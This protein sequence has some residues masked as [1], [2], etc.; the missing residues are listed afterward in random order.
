MIKKFIIGTIL[1]IILLFGIYFLYENFQR[2]NPSKIP[3]EGIDEAQI[4]NEEE[5]IDFAKQNEQI[6]S[7]A[8]RVKDL[9]VGYNA[10]YNEELE[11][12]QV[13]AYA[14][15]ANDLDYQISFYPNGTITFLGPIPM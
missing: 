12:W 13:V 5:A 4:N 3:I 9:G 11:V 15:N 1:V 14:K 8:E 6:K 2:N 7:F 10:Y